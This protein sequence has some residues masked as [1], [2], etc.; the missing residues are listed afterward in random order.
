M[1]GRWSEE[2]CRKLIN[3]V[4]G[5]PCL[6]HKKDSE[7]LNKSVRVSVWERIETEMR[8]ENGE[9][10]QKF[11]SLRDEYARVIKGTRKGFPFTKDML[12]LRGE[13]V[14]RTSV[15]KRMR[16]ELNQQSR[17]DSDEVSDGLVE[18]DTAS[19]VNSRTHRIA[20]NINNLYSNCFLSME[21]T[22]ADE[23]EEV[24]LGREI[25]FV[26]ET[27]SSSLLPVKI[28]LPTTIAPLPSG[29]ESTTEWTA[30]QD[31]FAITSEDYHFC[32]TILRTMNDLPKHL[33]RK[34]QVKIFK[35]VVDDVAEYDGSS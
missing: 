35:M 3:L 19:S 16:L 25:S 2:Q 34:L 28:S 8:T 4:G 21:D 10:Q 6:W 33:K 20:D 26:P 17:D 29:S 24:D 30:P 27:A 11:K 23:E 18:D 12:F 31:N 15:G 9:S 14:P 22:Q 1:A 5:V 13:I 32:N 7:Y